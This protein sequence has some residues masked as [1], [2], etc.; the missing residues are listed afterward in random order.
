VR[1][2]ECALRKQTDQRLASA[3]FRILPRTFASRM[4]MGMWMEE[5][6]EACLYVSK[7]ILWCSLPS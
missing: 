2:G 7:A 5:Q 4:W 6:E 1:V 3:A